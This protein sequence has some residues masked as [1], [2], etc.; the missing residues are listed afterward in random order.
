MTPPDNIIIN[1]NMTTKKTEIETPIAH[2]LEELFDIEEGTTMIPSV[3]HTSELVKVESYD[4]KDSEIESQFQEIYD[5]AMEAFDN[6]AQEV[7]VIDPRFKARN[8]EV[9]IQFLNAA[10]NAVK[11]KSNMKQQKDKL[12]VAKNKIQA[13]TVNNNLIVTDR[14]SLLESLK[15]DNIIDSDAFEE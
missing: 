5:T 12:N 13:G 11:E 14:N 6:Q 10:L 15:K 8:Q 1:I 7:E 9:A 4:D 3:E 2:P